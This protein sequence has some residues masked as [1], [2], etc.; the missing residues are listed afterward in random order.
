[1]ECNDT[2]NLFIL[3]K[4]QEVLHIGTLSGL[5]TFRNFK[6][7]NVVCL[8]LVCYKCDEIMAG[9]D[10]EMIDV[11][12]ICELCSDCSLSS[13]TDCFVLSSG[14]TLSKTFLCNVDYDIF[15]LNEIFRRSIIKF[16]F[17]NNSPSFIS[18]LFTNVSYFLLNNFKNMNSIREYIVILSNSLLDFFQF[19][20]NLICFKMAQSSK[21]H[22]DDGISLNLC[23]IKGFL[24]FKRS[25]CIISTIFDDL[26]NSIDVLKT[27]LETKENVFSFLSLLEIIS[28]SSL[29]DIFSVVNVDLKHVFDVKK[30]WGTVIKG[31]VVDI[32]VSLKSS[33]LPKHI[34]YYIWNCIRL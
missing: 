30:L 14:E 21:L 15:F 20:K 11:I 9:T 22:V 28:C 27:F 19:T 25:D 26:D 5:S 3:L 4:L 1:M 32:E 10:K 29:N 16:L 34:Q 31:K 17:N 12:T 8:T 2:S 13:L 33:A 7:L 18:V 23:K 6:C 24:K